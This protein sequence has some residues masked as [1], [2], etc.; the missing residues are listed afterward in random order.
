MKTYKE[1]AIEI[2][3]TENVKL[4]KENVQTLMSFS[5]ENGREFINN[6]GLEI[7]RMVIENSNDFTKDIAEKML[8]VVDNT[9]TENETRDFDIELTEKQ[10]WCIAYQIKNNINVYTL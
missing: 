8:K 5:Y 1:T 7:L 10:A 4:I 3:K 2:I 9:N 6:I